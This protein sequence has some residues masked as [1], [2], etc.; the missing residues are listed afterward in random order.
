MCVF[1]QETAGAPPEWQ[2]LPPG[3]SGPVFPQ[4]TPSA[5]R[6]CSAIGWTSPSRLP[7]G[8]GALSRSQ[9]AALTRQQVC[10]L[11]PS[12]AATGWG[13][14][15]GRSE[16]GGGEEGFLP[17][18]WWRAR[19]GETER[20][21]WTALE[22]AETV[23][24]IS[25]KAVSNNELSSLFNVGQSC[26]LLWNH[27]TTCL[28]TLMQKKAQKC[29]QLTPD[30]RAEQRNS[31]ERRSETVYTLNFSSENAA[32]SLFCAVIKPTK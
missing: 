18:G 32:L 21:G 4:A 2:I 14:S 22:G 1:I 15:G 8:R 24:R 5:P 17:R 7:I 16:R 11:S 29:E 20:R 6:G 13:Q 26:L 31:N 9:P 10:R 30:G 28:N 3:E 27:V 19:R 23:N 12:R 25:A